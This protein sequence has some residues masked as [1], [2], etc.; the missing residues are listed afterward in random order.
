MATMT[1]CVV[2]KVDSSRT[3]LDG[4]GMSDA[5]VRRAAAA[6]MW[7][8][9][10][11]SSINLQMRH[12]SWAV[13]RAWCRRRMLPSQRCIS[14]NPDPHRRRRHSRRSHRH[15]TAPPPAS[16]ACL[17]AIHT[18]TSLAAPQLCRRLRASPV[19]VCVSAALPCLDCGHVRTNVAYDPRTTQRVIGI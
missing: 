5:H 2:A 9:D 10:L 8:S 1:P 13:G 11:K 4:E 6:Q 3:R 15:R 7:G 19:P 16:T 18:S 17:A 12:A 14:V